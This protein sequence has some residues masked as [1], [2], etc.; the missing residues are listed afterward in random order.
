MIGLIFGIGVYVALAKRKED[1]GIDNA[2][3]G[4]VQGKLMEW[5]LGER[6]GFG[7]GR[8]RW[9]CHRDCLWIAINI[10]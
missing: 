1:Q 5:N 3:V 6:E 2:I 9:T 8:F 4:V 10:L 7:T